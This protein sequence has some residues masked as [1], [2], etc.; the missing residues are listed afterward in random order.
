[1][2]RFLSFPLQ[3]VLWWILV[4]TVYRVLFLLSLHFHHPEIALPHWW[5]SFFAGLRLD[6][7]TAA[8]LS[9]LPALLY[10]LLVFTKKLEKWIATSFYVLGGI[11]FTVM[12][13]NL[14]LYPAWGTL[15]NRRA[16]LFAGELNGMFASITSW[17]VFGI[18]FSTIAAAWTMIRSW[19]KTLSK[20]LKTES[21]GPKAFFIRFVWLP[22]L[23]WMIRGISL[24]PLNQSAAVF[25]N[26][27][28]LNHAAINPIFSLAENIFDAGFGT[29][30]P[31]EF[32]TLAEAQVN[33]KNYQDSSLSNYSILNSSKPNVLFLILESNT[34]DLLEENRMPFLLS[35]KKESIYFSN[36]YASGFRTDQ[37]FPAVFCGY[38]AQPNQSI[39][40]Q[41]DKTGFLPFLP[42]SLKQIGY[43]TSFFYGG[44]TD[45]A[46]MGNFLAEAGFD[47]ITSTDDF[48]QSSKQSK[49][50]A[51]DETVLMKQL[52]YLTASQKPF[53]SALLSLSLHEPFKVPGCEQWNAST[54]AEKFRKT[55]EYVDQSLKNYLQ[56]LKKTSFYQN[57][58]IVIVADHGHRLPKGRNYNDPE[59]H[60]IPLF[61]TGGALKPSLRGCNFTHP[62]SQTDIPKTI[63]NQLGIESSQFIRTNDLL[64]PT[65]SSFAYLCYDETI[66]WVDDS[67][68][69]EL[70]IIP[71][72]QKIDP[73][74]K[75]AYSFLQLLYTD[76]LNR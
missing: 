2:K 57:T 73:K 76:Y 53:F 64:H 58:L 23:F 1:M 71:K 72:P 19:N 47:H 26:V 4:F 68:Y 43:Q 6:L 60:K 29:T 8:Y 39:M 21:S 61:I 37:M 67:G 14:M 46:N 35:L 3:L 38:P 40:R 36:C 49:W 70:S 56:A 48:P 74:N 22:I 24:I 9:A 59:S 75:A 69:R 12:L 33:W 34:S 11:G 13:A 54:D 62:A 7:S 52:E 55:A 31:F 15:I 66:G 10:L 18:V 65:K 25:S 63:A 20:A 44:E 16:L 51:N 27:Q 45:F 5:E 30:N 50:G 28:A 41:T 32:Y 17:Q 42:K